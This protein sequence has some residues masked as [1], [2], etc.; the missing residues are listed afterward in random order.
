MNNFIKFNSVFLISLLSVQFSSASGISVLKNTSG[1]SSVEVE[2]NDYSS[3]ANPIYSA[4]QVTG[5]MV[6]GDIDVFSFSLDAPSNMTLSAKRLEDKIEIF[7]PSGTKIFTDTNLYNASHNVGAVSNGTYLIK[8]TSTSN[9]PDSY[10]FTLSF[11]QNIKTME[12][13][14]LNL[15]SQNLVLRNIIMETNASLQTALVNISNL[16]SDK[17]VLQA[18]L[19]AANSDK[20][21]LQA[22]LGTANSKNTDLEAEI[23]T[24]RAAQSND[25]SGSGN[26]SNESE[27]EN[28]SKTASLKAYGLHASLLPGQA[29]HGAT[30][31]FTT[32]DGSSSW[33]LND[34]NTVSSELK[35][36]QA[37]SSVFRA[38]YLAET[39]SSGVYEHGTVS[40]NMPT[41]DTDGNGVHD[42][43]QKDIAVNAPFSGSSALHWKAAGVQ[44]G[45]ASITGRLIRSAGSGSGTYSTT[46]TI[47]GETVT[48]TGTWYVGYWGGTVTY[49]GDKYGLDITTLDSKGETWDLS[50]SAGY[51]NPSENQLQFGD[52]QLTDGSDEIRIVG[53]TLKRSGDTYTA[54]MRAVD[55]NPDTSW[56]DYIDWHVVVTDTNDGDNDGVPDFTDPVE[57]QTSSTTAD[58]SG[59]S[60]H[61]WPW[62]YN[63]N[64]ENWLYYNN[65]SVWSYKD[66]KWFTWDS[67]S[68]TWRQQSN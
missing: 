15:E 23:A 17:T 31:Y 6:K 9:S 4:V 25:N 55:G 62:V 37:G 64:H 58:L 26:Q 12:A 32:Y 65:N 41:A 54:N 27:K 60:W 40:L 49:D 42:W 63:H 36:S 52:I 34:Q 16:T 20:T 50:G 11:P 33:P 14:V 22:Q 47:T 44:S 29:S 48:A 35:P 21:V 66:N 56:G 43:L 1:T 57:I 18:Q 8:I 59:W 28:V 51:S 30:I 24:L 61:K 53:A 67:S 13:K 38:D 5:N 39:V 7:S 2:P 68:E 3:K 19:S 46:Y 10:D 45:S